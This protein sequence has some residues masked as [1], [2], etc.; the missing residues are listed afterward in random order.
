MIEDIHTIIHFME[1]KYLEE[2]GG[3][4]LDSQII[5]TEMESHRKRERVVCKIWPF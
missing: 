1:M 3:G 2:D 5:S 4:K